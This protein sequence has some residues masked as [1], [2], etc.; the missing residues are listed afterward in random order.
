[1]RRYND[2]LDALRFT[3]EEQEMLIRK[4]EQ[5]ANA[6]QQPRRRRHPRRVLCI[7]AAV[8]CALTVTAAAANSLAP[9]FQAYFANSTPAAKQTLAESVLPLDLE[10]SHG[11]YTIRL[12]ECIGDDSRL[13]I[14]GTL[15]MPEPL[16]E[17]ARPGLN[18]WKLTLR[19]SAFEQ[20]VMGG[21]IDYAW[22]QY[23]PKTYSVPFTLSYNINQD[24][25]GAVATI[26]I[27]GI[28]E[29]HEVGEKGT[30]SFDIQRELICEEPFIFSDFHLD[31][32]TPSIT[33]HPN[34]ETVLPYESTRQ[35]VTMSDITL[36]P[37]STVVTYVGDMSKVEFPNGTGLPPVSFYD[38]NGNELPFESS[39]GSG[40]HSS[41]YYTYNQYYYQLID[42]S[43][44][45][46]IE[47]N[48][49][50]IDIP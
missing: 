41:W 44:I 16:D 39:G 12:T 4:L 30:L 46:Y 26:Q 14:S 19:E 20:A 35:T 29:E 23:D 33:L 25:Q 15:T 40:S 17:S 2:A 22:D 47:V 28:Y 3:E 32:Q 34:I 21:G 37:L 5:A 49:I 31:Y 6:A 38:S 13:L 9:I 8:A 18:G 45:S 7:A 48:D 1:M 50:R 36:T 11:G 43:Q 10:Q 27:D 42:L 24:L